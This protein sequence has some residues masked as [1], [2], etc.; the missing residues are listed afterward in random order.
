MKVSCQMQTKSGMYAQYDCYVD[1]RCHDSAE[2]NEVFQAT[3]KELQRTAFPD[4]NI[5]DV[6]INWL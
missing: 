5:P 2:W 3:V 6:E 1:V 4:Y